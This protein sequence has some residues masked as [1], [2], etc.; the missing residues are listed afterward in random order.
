MHIRSRIESEIG[1]TA[2]AG[3][4]CNKLLAKMVGKLNKPNGQ[5]YLPY[6]REDIINF[7]YPQNIKEVPGIGNVL[8]NKLILM[9]IL[10]C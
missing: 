9:Q 3:I 7:I 10:T 1:I 4:A 2:S 6:T 5:F 8:C